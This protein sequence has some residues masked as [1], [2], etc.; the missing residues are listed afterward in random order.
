MCVH[1]VITVNLLTDRR[2]IFTCV[3]GSFPYRYIGNGTCFFWLMLI[4]TV[5]LYGVAFGH[6]N[7]THYG[8]GIGYPNR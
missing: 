6:N 8:W 2:D 3:A 5:A 1:M 7:A 4:S